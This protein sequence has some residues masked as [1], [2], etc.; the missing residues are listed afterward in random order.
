MSVTLFEPALR[1]LLDTQEGPVGLF[2]QRKTA[3]VLDQAKTNARAY[4]GSAPSIDIERDVIS[5]MEG[6]TGVIAIVDGGSK[7]RRLAQAEKD[8]KISVGLRQALE[9]AR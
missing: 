5:E 6:S 2:I 9:A 1:A 7:S 3:R 4:Y 8:G